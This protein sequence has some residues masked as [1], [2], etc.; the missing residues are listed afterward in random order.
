MTTFI[1]HASQTS[2]HAPQQAVLLDGKLVASEIR[3]K[4]QEDIEA[5][6]ARQPVL[7]GLAVVRVG[8]DPASV[9]YAERIVQSFKKVGLLAT[10]FE[11]P[12]TATRAMLH[13][14]LDRLKVLPEFAAVMVQ[15][16]LPPHL[17][18]D[19]VIDD[20]DPN[21]D[22][23]GSHPMNIG[24]L[25]LGLDCYVP[26]TPAG[27]MALLDYY[28]IPIEGKRALVVG[29]SGIVGRPMSQLLLARHATVTI[30]HSRT[31]DLPSLVREADILAVATGKPGLI[32]GEMLKPGAVVI[33]F[34][35]SYV[36]GQM[37]GDV[38]FGS[39]VRVAG[40]ITP[41]PGGTGPMT[42]AMLLRNT[43]KA[44]RRRGI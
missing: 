4:V 38:D 25:A 5:L 17:G 18:W 21:K 11:L 42:N 40:A 7:P 15:W 12:A 13:A 23:D 16:P 41:V 32:S 36:D 3:R 14:E 24:K 19:A 6:K 39:A 44:I 34:G 8:Q 30:A 22:V 10:V 27:G 33:D 31:R 43:L 37:R 20:L 35:A 29:R 9:S 1:D 2:E 26:A 28:H